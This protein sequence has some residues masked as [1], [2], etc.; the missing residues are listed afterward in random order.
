VILRL[1][2]TAYD[3]QIAALTAKLGD[4][5]LSGEE[6]DEALAGQQRLRAARRQPLHPLGEA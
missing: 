4:S 3:Q 1:R 2:N 5:S 6:H